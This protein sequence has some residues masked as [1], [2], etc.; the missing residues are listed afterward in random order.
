MNDGSLPEAYGRFLD[1]HRETSLLNSCAGLLGWD[2]ETYMPKGGAEIRSRQL[3]LLRGMAH[4]RSTGKEYGD[5]L[6][7]AEAAG[8]DAELHPEAVANLRDARRVYDRVV[9]VPAELVEEHTKTTVLARRAWVDAR[10][11]NEFPLFLPHLEAVFDVARR[12]AEAIGFEGSPYDAALDGYEPGETE[13]GIRELFEPLREAHVRLLQ[14]ILDSGRPVDTAVLHRNYPRE[15]QASLA[16][17]AAEAIGFDFERGRIDETAH[18][19]CAGTGPDDVRLT[20]RYHEDFF[21]P[22][23]FG[24]LHEAGHG[25][26]EQGLDMAHYGTPMGLACSFGVHES[27]SRMWENLVGRSRAFWRWCYPK[28]RAAF[29]EAL[30]GVG[31]EDFWRAVND[32]RPSLI[33]VEADEV[34]YNLHIM[35]RFELERAMLAGDLAPRDLPGAWNEAFQHSFGITPPDDADGCL[36]DIHWSAGLIGYFP[37]YTL[38]NVYAAQLYAAAERDLGELGPEFERGEFG[39]LRSWLNQNIHR[40]G[41]RFPARELV[42]RVCGEPPSPEPLIR[43]LE[44]RFRAIYDL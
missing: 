30:A 5:L 8:I 10:G 38:G 27:Q 42:E 44:S 3:A 41:R 17:A 18:P 2:Q 35:L 32:V 1:H 15:A 6:A 11:K 31:E 7:A 33:R 13:E 19:F 12:L 23:F 21:N 14:R 36:Q 22:A 28:A 40:H 9:N 20:T 43:Q 26:Y 29:P 16:R 34:T 25:L 4:R 37:T 39:H 24:T